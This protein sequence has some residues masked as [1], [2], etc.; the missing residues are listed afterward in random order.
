MPKQKTSKP[1]ARKPAPAKASKSS[2]G[3]SSQ[4]KPAELISAPVEVPARPAP[5]HDE[6]A[7]KAYEIWL[8]KG[9]PIGQDEANWAEAIEALS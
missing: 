5:T 2:A 3:K 4:P 1:P 9:R 6:I 7:A 8:E